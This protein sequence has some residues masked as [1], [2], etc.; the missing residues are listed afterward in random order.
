MEKNQLVNIVGVQLVACHERY[1]GLPNFA[2]LSKNELF[3][4]I[5]DRMWNKIKGWCHKLFSISGKEVLLKA[6]IQAILT[7]SMSLFHLL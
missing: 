6:I 5:K 3:A 2:S 1:L 7:Y 4:D